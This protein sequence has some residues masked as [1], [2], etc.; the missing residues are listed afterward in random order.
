MIGDQI[1]LMQT[2]MLPCDFG[3]RLTEN[4]KSSGI[5][6]YQ[7]KLVLWNNDNFYSKEGAV[8]PGI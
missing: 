3:D 4:K 2:I 7:D 5:R 8:I 1:V 6:S